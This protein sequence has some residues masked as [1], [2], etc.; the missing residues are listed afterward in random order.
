MMD[1]AYYPNSDI[2]SKAHIAKMEQY[3]EIY[4]RSIDE[5]IAFWE[6]T[7]KRIS[8]YE[9][10]HTLRNYDFV[11][12]N[13]EWFS[14]GK[15]NASYNCIDRHIE[16]GKSENIAIIWEGNDPN[17]SITFTYSQLLDKVC[18]FS[19]VLKKQNIKKGDRVCIYMQMIPELT[20]AMLACARIGAIH[21]IVFGAF[22][23]D[24]LRDRINDSECK[25]L[26]T[27]D[28]GVRGTKLD[29]AMKSK[30]DD[31]LKDTPTIQTVIT[32]SIFIFK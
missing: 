15:L 13:I 30:A 20:I 16:D 18:A 26:I 28:W 4:E 27:Q 24:S 25:M 5:P 11:N 31:A 21:S 10:W 14:G 6:E 3:K 23:S 1:K 29:I 12:G 2:S 7:A 9:P 22:S 32:V 17:E 19:N 8:W